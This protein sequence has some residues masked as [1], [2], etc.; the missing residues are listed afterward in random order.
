MLCTNILYSR[1]IIASAATLLLLTERIG[2]NNHYSIIAYLFQ[3][4]WP[5]CA[6]YIV[7]NT[8]TVSREHNYTSETRGFPIFCA[9]SIFCNRTRIWINVP[10]S[11]RNIC[12]GRF[13]VYHLMTFYRF[14]F[15]GAVWYLFLLLKSENQNIC[16][17]SVIDDRGDFYDL[18]LCGEL[19]F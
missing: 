7:Y 4:H 1:I 2:R 8:S 12:F 19:R 10:H 11:P 16:I 3:L 17:P 14:T 9:L 6:L 15:A 18:S 13:D 5:F